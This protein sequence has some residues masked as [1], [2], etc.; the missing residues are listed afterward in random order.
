MKK[1]LITGIYGQDGSYLSEI[2]HQDNYEIYG[3]CRKNLSVIAQ[4]NKKELEKEAIKI[5]ECNESIY[6]YAAISKLIREIRPN[7][8][9]HMAAIH[10]ASS[11]ISNNNI[12]AEKELYEMNVSATNNILTACYEESP[13]T[14]IVSAGSC[15]MYD[16]CTE[17]VQ[18]ENT[19]FSS[20]SMYGIAKIAENNLVKIYRQKGLFACTPI[21]Y[22]HESHRRSA[23]FVTKKIANGLKAI[24]EGQQDFIELGDIQ[25][26]KDWGFAGDYALA[27]K[28]MCEAK[29]PKDYIVATGELHSIEEYLSQ[30]ARELQIDDWRNYVKTNNELVTRTVRT[31]LC[32][33]PLR[34]ITELGWKHSIDFC[35]LVKEIMK[36]VD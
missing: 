15:L 7:V 12:L 26:K 9:F 36:E 19:V 28:L 33:N 30:C 21:L 20:R 18:N 23:D 25:V 27:M 2:M 32:G 14:R 1:V 35:G 31:S 5:I 24:K 17:K 34:C 22:N 29:E 6:D 13:S 4:K 16:D 11:S 10:R 8:V 3:L